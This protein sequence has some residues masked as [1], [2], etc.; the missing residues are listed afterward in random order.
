MKDPPMVNIL[1][2]NSTSDRPMDA[3]TKKKGTDRGR[4]ARAKKIS[5]K[6]HGGS[7]PAA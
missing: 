1:K 3:G 4:Y 6:G 7:K 5:M 2:G